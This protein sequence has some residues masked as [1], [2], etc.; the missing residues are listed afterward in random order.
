LIAVRKIEAAQEIAEVI[1]RNPNIMF[2]SEKTN[3]MLMIPAGPGLQVRP[4]TGGNV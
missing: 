1:A 4:H 3:N 2:V